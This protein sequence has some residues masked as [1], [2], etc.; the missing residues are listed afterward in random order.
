VNLRSLRDFDLI[1][2]LSGM[3]LMA[4]GAVLIYS[5]SLTTYGDITASFS[6]PVVRQVLFAAVGLGLAM[7]LALLDYRALGAVSVALYL[8]AIAALLF[9]LAVGETA[10]GSRR[11]IVV[12]DTNVQPSE[13]AKLVI[14]IVLAKYLAD[15]QERV[16]EPKVFLTSLGL[17]A[18]PTALVFAEPDLGS[19]VIFVAIWLGMVILAGARPSHIFGLIGAGLVSVPFVFLAFVS[20]Y[21]RERIALWLDPGSESLGSGFNILQAEI[22]IG[23]GGILGK[24]L[25]Q[26]T[27]TQLDYL[28]TQTTDYIFSVLGEELG[29]VGALLLFGLFVILLFRGIRAASLSQDVFGR[30]LAAGIVIFIVLQAFINIGVNLRILPVTGIPLPFISQGGSSLLTL[31]IALGILESI[32]LRHRR[33]QW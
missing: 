24:G 2:L 27:Q 31:F 17:A 4:F 22:S 6:H 7:L 9:V 21:Q 18:L 19:A 30:L 8:A 20:D 15:R 16:T 3:A 11:W 10:Y 32:V 12:G 1:L 25:T 5:G 13:I 23:S 14:I 29:L 28:R 33:H 26:G